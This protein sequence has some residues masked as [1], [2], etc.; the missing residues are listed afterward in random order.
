MNNNND[1]NRDNNSN[2]RQKL[3]SGSLS[4]HLI[5]FTA[6]SMNGQREVITAYVNPTT[7]IRDIKI[8][9][10]SICNNKLP[11]RCNVSLFIIGCENEILQ[12]NDQLMNSEIFVIMTDH[13]SRPLILNSQS[14]EEGDKLK[15]IRRLD[16]CVRYFKVLPQ[17]DDN[18]NDFVVV[19]EKYDFGNNK[20]DWNECGYRMRYLDLDQEMDIVSSKW[21]DDPA[22]DE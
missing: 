14:F 2:K 3:V 20:V 18:L 22:F 4:N 21:S 19:A 11:H 6:L 16:G 7:A 10:I 17:N 1:N 12:W 8:H 9:I 15:W 5:R 13:T